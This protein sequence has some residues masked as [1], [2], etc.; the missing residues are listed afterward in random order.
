MTQAAAATDYP[1]EH[2][3]R[4]GET[5][6]LLHGGNVA[7]WMWEPQVQRLPGRH[8]LTPDLP[9]YGARTD[10]IWPGLAGVADDVASLVRDRAVGGRAHVVGLSLGGHVAMHL[11][12]RHP[13]LVRTVTVTGV[14]AAGL[15]RLERLLITPQVPLWNRRW[16]WAAQA[17][18][19][20]IP[21]DGRELFV[22][23]GSSVRPETNRR[24]FHEVAAGTMPSGGI[25]FHGPVLAVSG[26]RESRSVRG[27]FARLGAAIPQLRTWIAPRMHHTWSVEDPDLFTRMVTTHTET[28]VWPPGRG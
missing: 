22:T 21:A 2:G 11:I 17:V 16:Y 8:L 5:I 20:G 26:E 13:E 19:F 25:D 9:G 10:V 28:G 7:G 27:A 6:V 24:M 18:A 1:L 23:S 12:Q 3:P 14:A 15:G 4:E